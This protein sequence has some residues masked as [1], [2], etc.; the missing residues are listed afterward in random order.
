MPDKDWVIAFGCFAL[1]VRRR[2][3]KGN[4]TDFAVVLVSHLNGEWKDISRYD[5]PHGMV[6]RDIMGTKQGLR[7][8]RWMDDIEF[9]E[10]FEYAIR[11]FI[12]NAESYLEDYL[13]H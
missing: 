10:A 7:F 3:V 11:D 8:K 13:A 1:L 6:H 2:T 9:N 12:E 5:T 4:I